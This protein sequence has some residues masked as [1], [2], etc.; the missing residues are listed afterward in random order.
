MTS[1]FSRVYHPH[2][3]ALGKDPCTH[4]YYWTCTSHGLMLTEVR[5][6]G[7]RLGRLI[8]AWIG[9]L[10][11]LP[12]LPNVKCCVRARARVCVCAYVRGCV[13][14]R[15]RGNRLGRL[16]RLGSAFI[17]AVWRVPN[18]CLTF[19]T[20]VLNRYAIATLPRLCRRLRPT[21]VPAIA[22]RWGVP[23]AGHAVAF[24][25]ATTSQFA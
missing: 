19:L 13:C 12:N 23:V 21:Y 4:L 10:P 16:G 22:G 20:S 15:R 11:N 2:G 25:N 14:A 3:E 6:V 9:L 18:L 7:Q 24:L 8:T 17:H 5:K 1:F